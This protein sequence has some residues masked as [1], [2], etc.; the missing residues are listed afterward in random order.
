MVN[1]LI[2]LK[3]IL[4]FLI[5]VVCAATATPSYKMMPTHDGLM[6]RVAQWTPSIDHPERPIIL[7]L[8]G[9]GETLEQLDDRAKH[10]TKMGFH[11]IA[12]EWRGHG[13]SGRMT[14]VDSLHHVPDFKLYLQDLKDVLDQ[15]PRHQKIFALCNSMGGHLMI[16]Y[17]QEFG[18]DQRFVGLVLCA[19]MFRINTGKYPYTLA[20]GIAWMANW[21]G[22]SESFVLGYKPFE[23]G[24]CH[25]NEAH[26]GHRGHREKQCL[27]ENAHA[28]HAIGGPSYSWLKAAF[29]SSDQLVKPQKLKSILV[30]VMILGVPNDHKV[31]LDIQKEVCQVLPKCKIK[32][33]DNAHHNLFYEDDSVQNQLWQD[34]STFYFEVMS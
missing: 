22:L 24:T 33:Y 3:K 26:H 13:Q 19:P 29:H 9:F 25:Y 12:P 11:V 18:H 17:L 1:K 14:T 32:E 28:M 30:P 31:E 23:P 15:Q 6:I 20:K 4:S 10:L 5:L 16:R 27:I 8:G 21:V 7:L 34:F 2:F